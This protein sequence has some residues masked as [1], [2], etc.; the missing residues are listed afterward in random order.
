MCVGRLQVLIVTKQRVNR[1]TQPCLNNLQNAIRP[2]SWVAVPGLSSPLRDRDRG[3]REREREFSTSR[4]GPL[5]TDVS[6]SH[7]VRR[8]QES[9]DVSGAPVRS[10]QPPPSRRPAQP[11]AAA[12]AA[13][14]T[15]RPS[16]VPTFRAQAA[17][18]SGLALALP[19]RPFLELSFK[20][21]GFLR[22]LASL[23]KWPPSTASLPGFRLR[24]ALGAWSRAARHFAAFSV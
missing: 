17:G 6:A 13:Q 12:A 9:C 20:L 15:A 1:R 8:M 23:L 18:G 22:A 11:P 14:L 24:L 21:A 7:K 10:C 4:D 19:L 2:R 3:Q 16:A 5:R